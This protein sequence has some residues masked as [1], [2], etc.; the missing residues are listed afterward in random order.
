YDVS[1]K[2]SNYAKF[3]FE[4][5]NLQEIEK[6]IK[7]VTK[8]LNLKEVYRLEAKLLTNVEGSNTRGEASSSQSAVKSEAIQEVAMKI[9]ES[10]NNNTLAPLLYSK[11]TLDQ[12]VNA[13]TSI[14]RSSAL[15]GQHIQSKD[16]TDAIKADRLFRR[17]NSDYIFVSTKPP[18]N[19][20]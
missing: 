9:M 10:G 8:P 12:A 19:I 4:L 3:Y 15:H 17:S 5:R 18:A 6:K 14:G 16:A 11:T 13:A 1:V 2:L 7:R 20:M